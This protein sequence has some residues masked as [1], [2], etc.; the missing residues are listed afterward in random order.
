MTDSI[1][2]KIANLIYHR[3]FASP[4]SLTEA[5]LAIMRERIESLPV[6]P[7]TW[8]TVLDAIEMTQGNHDDGVY[9]GVAI[10]RARAI[11]EISEL[12]ATAQS[13][14]P[15]WHTTACYAEGRRSPGCDLDAGITP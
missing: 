10:G 14:C 4:G 3:D 7:D 11:R 2:D 15:P 8:M 1:R 13:C 12:F 5:I 6:D 9:A